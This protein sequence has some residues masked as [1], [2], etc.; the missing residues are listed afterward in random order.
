MGKRPK[1][2]GRRPGGRDRQFFPGLSGLARGIDAAIDKNKPK[3]SAEELLAERAEVERQK[4][5]EAEAKRKRKAYARLRQAGL[6][7]EKPR[8]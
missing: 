4:K 5:D 7:K 6:I 2:E 8:G 1:T 3:Q